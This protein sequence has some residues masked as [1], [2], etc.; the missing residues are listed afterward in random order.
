[1]SVLSGTVKESWLLRSEVAEVG[2][3]RSYCGPTKGQLKVCV[4]G[5]VDGDG[6]GGGFGGGGGGSSGWYCLCV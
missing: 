4:R 6:G 2:W 1:M 3:G 5:V